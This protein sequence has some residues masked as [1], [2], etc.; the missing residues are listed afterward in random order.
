[1]NK[2]LLDRKDPQHII[3]YRFT[4]IFQQKFQTENNDNITFT[5]TYNPNHNTVHSGLDRIKNKELKTC[6]QKKYYSSPCN[7]Q[8]YVNFK[9]QQGF[10]PCAKCVCHKS[11][12]FKECLFFLFKS[13]KKIA[14]LTL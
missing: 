5:R 8:T 3:D 13:E 14:D 2:H 4:K 12:Y 1:M 11:V 9:P 10:S 6:F 7:P